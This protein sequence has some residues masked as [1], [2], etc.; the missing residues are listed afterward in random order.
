MPDKNKKRDTDA[1]D[2]V[3]PD[4][5]VDALADDT[6]AKIEEDEDEWVDGAV[7]DPDEDF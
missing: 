1:E 4:A 3:D 6:D 5:V 2:V 7:K